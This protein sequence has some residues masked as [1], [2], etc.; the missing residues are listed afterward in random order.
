MDGIITNATST[1]LATTGF[2]LSSDV[3]FMTDQILLVVGSGLGVL[4]Y[5]LPWIVGIAVISAI[6]YF[7]FRAFS[8]FRH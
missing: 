4:E 3:D 2:E 7:L 5:L 6:V 8:F 1:F